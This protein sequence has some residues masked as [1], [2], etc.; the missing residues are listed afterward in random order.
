[1]YNF[2]K[3]INRK[4]T[5][6]VK[7]SDQSADD[8]IA[9]WIADMDFPAPKEVAQAI[10]SRMDH[11]IFGYTLIDDEFYNVFIEWMKKR[12]N[13]VVE[14]EHIV[15]TSC[16]VA[17]LGVAIASF[18]SSDDGVLVMPPVYPPFLELPMLQ[19]LRRVDVPL[20]HD[21]DENTYK[22]D[23]DLFEE[24]AKEAKIFILCSPHNPVGRVWTHDELKRMADIIVKND[25]IILSD[26]IHSDIIMPG[27]KHLPTGSI[28][29][30][31]NER[32]VSIYAP[33]KTFNIP[34][35]PTSYNI[36][37]NKEL[38]DK[39]TKTLAGLGLTNQSITS[40]LAS[41]VAYKHGEKW[42]QEVLDYIYKNYLFI[43]EYLKENIPSVK[44]SK[45]EGTYLAWLDFRAL[46]LS[47]DELKDFLLNKARL[48]LKSGSDFDSKNGLCFM[49][50]NMATSR[51][52][53]KEA[54]DRMKNAIEGL[55]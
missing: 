31:L 30:A 39:F 50:F 45:V 8:I 16:V 26:E 43:C 37:P 24:K 27:Y 17:S 34:G 7:W 32:L 42:L 51:E 14:R 48:N 1:M 6:S 33:N 12:Y 25:M 47:D 35:M 52:V 15:T 38:R 28:S 36:I 46:S 18:A 41:K 9:L 2:D 21:E 23:F 53:I 54:L 55:K 44:I 40:T 5:F 10:K 11:E 13:F 22:I 19:G 20:I 49:R 29:E 4:D 3:I